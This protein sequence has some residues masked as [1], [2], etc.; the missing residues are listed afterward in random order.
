MRKYPFQKEV[1][2]DFIFRSGQVCS[3]MKNFHKIAGC[4]L[5]YQ[6]EVKVL[7]IA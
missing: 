1:N 3:D 7:K 5:D 2:L 6:T 4:A